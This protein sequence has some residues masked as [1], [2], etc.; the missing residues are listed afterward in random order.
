MILTHKA[1]LILRIQKNAFKSQD[2]KFSLQMMIR[3][4]ISRIGK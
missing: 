3:R 1:I 4:K 2:S